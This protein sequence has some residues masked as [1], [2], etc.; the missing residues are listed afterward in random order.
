MSAYDDLRLPPFHIAAAKL[1]VS[2]FQPIFAAVAPLTQATAPRSAPSCFS[3]YAPSA[4]FSRC[5]ILFAAGRRRAS[6]LAAD[7][8]AD[9]SSPL[10]RR[11]RRCAFFEEHIC[12]L[13][14]CRLRRHAAIFATRRYFERRLRLRCAFAQPSMYTSEPLLAHIRLHANKGTGCHHYRHQMNT[15]PSTTCSLPSMSDH[16]PAAIPSTLTE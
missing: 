13:R 7:Y 4:R 12:R 14:A 10:C 2:S 11:C 3:A 1:S 6:A 15:F 5:Q 9:S 16:P 8:A